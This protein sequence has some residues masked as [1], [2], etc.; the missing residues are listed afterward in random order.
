MSP[1]H[2]DCA[3]AFAMCATAIR[4]PLASATLRNFQR[5]ARPKQCGCGALALAR[6][7]SGLR[8]MRAP[9]SAQLRMR[10]GGPRGKASL[11]V[12]PL[13]APVR[14]SELQIEMRRCRRSLAALCCPL[15]DSQTAGGRVCDI[16]A[17]MPLPSLL[18]ALL[19]AR[20]KYG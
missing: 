16:A 15:D 12:A 2:C 19:P 4:L 13:A 1:S 5:T 14:S 20:Y 11:G 8:R 6:A 9:S 7:V 3:N 10:R 18:P 17:R